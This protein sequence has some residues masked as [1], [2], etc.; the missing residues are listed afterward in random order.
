MSKQSVPPVIEQR[1]RAIVRALDTARVTM[2]RKPGRYVID[3]A[4]GLCLLARF[5]WTPAKAALVRVL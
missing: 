4:E 3:V 2:T 5:T 1:L